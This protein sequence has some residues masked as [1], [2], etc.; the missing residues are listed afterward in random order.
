V[1]RLALLLLRLEIRGDW[2]R[3]SPTQHTN[4]K[5]DGILRTPRA[6]RIACGVAKRW[7][8]VRRRRTPQRPASDVHGMYPARTIQAPRSAIF[9]TN[10]SRG[11]SSKIS[12]CQRRVGPAPPH[13]QDTT[14]PAFRC[15][16]GRHHGARHCTATPLSWAPDRVTPP[17]Q[18]VG[19]SDRGVVASTRSGAPRFKTPSR[20]IGSL[21]SVSSSPMAQTT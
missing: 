1:A 3:S 6:R 9:S 10:R 8:E 14:I 4:S 16:R 2:L 13:P 19:A 11:E 21:P 20:A 12:G 17:V 7:S 5:S 18:P 15:G